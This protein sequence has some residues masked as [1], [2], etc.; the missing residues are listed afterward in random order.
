[1]QR[2]KYSSTVVLTYE[3]E[4]K[5]A[6]NRSDSRLKQR[7]KID[8]FELIVEVCFMLKRIFFRICIEKLKNRKWLNLKNHQKNF[9][10]NLQKIIEMFLLSN[11]CRNE[12]NFSMTFCANDW[13]VVIIVKLNERNC[14]F[15]Y[16]LTLNFDH[17]LRLFDVLID[18]FVFN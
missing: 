2:D 3:N 10:E 9:Y 16:K 7:W 12:L 11:R 18:F 1:M 13:S 17:I 4:V 8:I 6:R 14:F 15:F 5:I